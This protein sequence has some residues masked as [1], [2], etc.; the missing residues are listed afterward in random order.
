ML[1]LMPR[2][3]KKSSSTTVLPEPEMSLYVDSDGAA[4]D[5]D[6]LEAWRVAAK[7]LASAY[8]DW[9]A[10]G[11]RDRRRCYLSF[12]DAFIHEET[13]AR[14]L[15]RRASAVGTAHAGPPPT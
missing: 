12:V 15:Q 6:Q 10:A 8:D 5:A 14:R 2:R 3:T 4:G 11:R 9:C 1:V 13:T 7:E